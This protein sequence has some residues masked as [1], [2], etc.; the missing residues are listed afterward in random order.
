MSGSHVASAKPNRLAS[1][2]MRAG[3]QLVGVLLAA[4][5]LAGCGG[6]YVI[7]AP[8]Q[9]AKAGEDAAIVIRLQRND[10]DMIDMATKDAPVRFR[11]DAG[12]SRFAYTDSD[13]YAG[14][15]VPTPADP[16]RY[17]MEIFHK[18][19]DG[20]EITGYAPVYVWGPDDLIVAVDVESLPLDALASDR[21][22]A[23]AALDAISKQAAVIYLSRESISDFA[24]LRRHGGDYQRP[25]FF[26]L[27]PLAAPGNLFGAQD[28]PDANRAKPDFCDR[29]LAFR[30]DVVA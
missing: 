21:R 25:E 5:G 14:T 28:Q 13:G 24:D 4:W 12:D 19:T 30:N 15:I 23:R 20:I 1:M 16:G 11:I 9:L 3:R 8:D 17:I 29:P 22:A 27:L 18:D 10:F 26:Q 2:I 6:Y 7:T